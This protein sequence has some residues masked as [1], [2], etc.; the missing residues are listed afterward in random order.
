MTA[1]STPETSLVIAIR[2]A[3]DAYLC[4]CGLGLCEESQA[5]IIE[6]LILAAWAVVKHI[7]ELTPERFGVLLGASAELLA[8]RDLEPMVL[9]S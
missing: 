7:P 3:V 4:S 8:E 2:D 5:A 9:H 6:P 1:N